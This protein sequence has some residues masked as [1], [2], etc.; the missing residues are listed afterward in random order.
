MLARQGENQLEH[1]VGRGL[2]RAIKSMAPQAYLIGEN[3]FDA[4]PQLQGD[5]LD[6]TMN[7]PGFSVPLQ[8]W[9]VGFDA[10]LAWRPNMQDPDLLPTAALAD[11]WQSFIAAVPWQIAAQQFNLLDSHDT[12]RIQTV[13]GEDETLARIAVTLLFTFPGTPS[14]Y[15]GDEIGIAGGHDPDNR[16]CMIWDERQWNSGRRAFYQ[17]CIHLRRSS[18]ALHHGGFQILYASGETLA[19]LREAPEERLIVVARRATDGLVALPVRHGGLPDGLVLQEVFS[20]AETRVEQGMLF[21][22]SL[23]DAGMQVWRC[24]RPRLYEY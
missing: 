17:Q 20:G 1:K 16:R 6:A 19:F 7:Y 14:V 18:P 12:R 23:P 2:R 21:L 11:Q 24:T 22:S 5:E 9:L 4:S 15:Y 10:S 8:Q 13:V 3:F